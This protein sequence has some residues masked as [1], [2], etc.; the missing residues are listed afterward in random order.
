VFRRSDHDLAQRTV[1]VPPNTTAL[2]ST[3]P[4]M[5]GHIPSNILVGGTSIE[6]EYLPNIISYFR[7]QQ[8]NVSGPRPMTA[9]K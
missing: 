5:P 1:T 4:G 6:M 3:P 7:I 2:T 8:T 9:F